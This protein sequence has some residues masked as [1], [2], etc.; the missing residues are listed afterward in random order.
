[1]NSSFLSKSQVKTQNKIIKDLIKN[2][3]EN[4]YSADSKISVIHELSKYTSKETFEIR[5]REIKKDLE[6]KRNFSLISREE[7][8]NRRRP[9][10]SPL[11]RSRSNRG[12]NTQSN[13]QQQNRGRNSQSHQHQQSSSSSNQTQRRNQRS[14][15]PR[16]DQY[17]Q[18]SS[19]S[20]QHQ[21]RNQNFNQQR[22]SNPQ[23]RN[24]R[25]RSPERRNQRHQ[26]Q[27]S[28]SSLPLS[29][30]R[31]LGIVSPLKAQQL[32]V[33]HL[34]VIQKNRLIGCQ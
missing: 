29:G 6:E 31:L 24:Q 1:M 12:R 4:I 18:S 28:S 22:S 17:Q 5:S 8:L 33:Y 34:F 13:Q 2:L 7:A 11:R 21:G 23:R 3:N 16:R 27:Q 19:S 25:S 26:S 30:A 9:S 10:R 14:Q 15:S 20:N 32:P